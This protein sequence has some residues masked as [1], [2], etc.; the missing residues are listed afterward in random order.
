MI[1]V[2]HKGKP[3]LD[4]KSKHVIDLFFNAAWWELRV[5]EQVAQWGEVK[6]LLINCILPFKTTSQDKKNE[7]DILVSTGKKL[8]FIECKSGNVKQEDIDK[9]KVIKDTYGGLISKSILVSRY[10][11]PLGIIEKCEELDIDVFYTHAFKGTQTTPL[12][13]LIPKLNDLVKRG[14]I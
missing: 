8:I 12:N 4:L 1:S 3:I 10:I 11:P 9:M 14:S 7:I 6:Q 5:A 13:K 2:K